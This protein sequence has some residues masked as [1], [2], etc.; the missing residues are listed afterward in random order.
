MS[1]MS[2]R[3]TTG[4]I[5]QVTEVMSLVCCSDRPNDR[6]RLV[7]WTQHASN[8]KA[9]RSTPLQKLM[10]LVGRKTRCSICSR[11]GRTVPL[12]R[13]ALWPAPEVQFGHYRVAIWRVCCWHQPST[14]IS[15]CPFR[16]FLARLPMTWN[17]TA[18]CSLSDSFIN[19]N[20]ASS[21]TTTPDIKIVSTK[22]IEHI[23]IPGI[24]EQS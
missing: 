2:D 7:T 16:E 19:L 1:V 22:Y 9:V 10:C 13:L 15:K 11:T 23:L 6:G 18:K 20:L 17:C 8:P 24:W 4:I 14:F 12:I 5:G 21:V 3:M